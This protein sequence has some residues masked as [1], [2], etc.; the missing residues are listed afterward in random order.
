MTRN[1]KQQSLRVRE[2]GRENSARGTK[3]TTSHRY[4]YYII[5]PLKYIQGP[6]GFR[7]QR[8]GFQLEFS[9]PSRQYH[10]H[11]RRGCAEKR[12]GRL[13]QGHPDAK[14]AMFTRIV[15]Q[16]HNDNFTISLIRIVVN[17]TP[18][19]SRR[20][21]RRACRV[22]GVAFSER[23]CRRIRCGNK[24]TGRFFSRPGTGEE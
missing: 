24:A 8:W 23:V 19:E 12:D 14:P 16:Q 10:H 11:R 15:R 1:P 20:S 17:T 5:R 3:S 7:P 9:N 13:E 18:Y 2:E 22:L 4:Y 6:C 21:S